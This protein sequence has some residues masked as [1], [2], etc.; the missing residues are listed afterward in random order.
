VSVV[1]RV[2]GLTVRAGRDGPAIIEGLSLDVAQGEILG[3][4][5]ESGSGKTTLGLSLLG[6]GRDGAVITEGDIRV[7]EV[8]MVTASQSELSRHRGSLVSYVPQDPAGALNP[9][10]RIGSQLREVLALADPPP[11]KAEALDLIRSS[12]AEMDLPTDPPF[13]RRYPHE[14][15]GGQQQRLLLCLAFLRGPSVVVLDEP[16]TGLDVTTQA[17]VLDTVRAACARHGCAAVFVTHDL[18]V[19]GSIAHRVLVMYGGRLAEFGETSQIFAAP[20]HPYTSALLAAAPSL[21]ADDSLVGIPGRAPRLSE[22]PDGCIFAPRCALADERCDTQPELVAVD[23]GHLVACHRP[24]TATAVRVPRAVHDETREDSAD[25]SALRVRGLRAGYSGKEVV[26]GVDLDIVRGECV[27]VVGESGSGKTTLSQCIAGLQVPTHGEISLD[28]RPLAR[29]AR[30]RSVED[31]RALQY[32]FQNPY[33]SLNPRKTVAHLLSQPCAVLGLPSPD[34]RHLLEQVQLGAHVL[35]M[36][37]RQL[38]G[39]E[40]QRVAVA[41]ALSSSPEFLICDEITSALDVSIQASVV[42]LIQRL[43]RS[44]G[45]GVLFVTHNLPLVGAIADRVVVMQR[46]LVVEHGSVD[47]VLRQP[48]TEYAVQ[49]LDAVP[50]R[51]AFDSAASLRSRSDFAVDR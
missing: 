22:R 8:S 35:S 1:L 20:H 17:K 34:L 23:E 42:E 50:S 16:T 33:G 36:R 10:I 25:T 28:G 19:V 27:A 29:S 37:P 44:T 49:L 38:S 46:G 43:Q 14:L 51:P 31:R 13:L 45:I 3:V 7:G 2:E 26:H 4:V 40:R 30:D 48:S 39:G 5:G 47:S 9:V 21:H 6:Y 24:Q 11:S 18:D 32:V 15:S 12:L 41:R